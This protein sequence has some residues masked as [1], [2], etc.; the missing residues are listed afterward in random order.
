MFTTIFTF[1]LNSFWVYGVLGGGVGGAEPV[2]T[3]S[4]RTHVRSRLPSADALVCLQLNTYLMMLEYSDSY[5]TY[6]ICS[7]QYLDSI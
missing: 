6:R 1:D 4:R 3:D 2:K 7:Q 5:E